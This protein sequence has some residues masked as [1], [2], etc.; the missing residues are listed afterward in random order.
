VLKHLS[1]KNYALIDS[2]EIEFHEGLSII[3]GETGAGKSILLGALSLILGQRADSSVIKNAEGK[4]IVEGIFSIINC[5]LE[6]FFSEN[7]IDLD[8]EAILRREISQDG[9]SRAFINDTPV[10]LNILRDLGVQL[11]DIHSQH[12]NLD[13]NDSRFQLNIID[14]FSGN[15]GLLDDYKTTFKEYIKVKTNLEKLTGEAGKSKEDFEYFKYRFDELEKARLEE[16]EKEVLEEE[17]SALGHSDDIQRN[18]ANIFNYFSENPESVIF[19]LN[20]SLKSAH[21]ISEY[22][23]KLKE[24]SQRIE[25][26]FIEIKDV[27]SEIEIL[28]GK[29]QFDPERFAFVNER[30]DLIYNL[31]QKHK[32]SSIAELDR[33][34]QEL[35]SKINDIESFDDRLKALNEDFL[36]KQKNLETLSEQL[37]KKRKTSFDTIE[38]Y[39]MEQ[40]KSL[41][42]P[43]AAFFVRHEIQADFTPNGKDKI[44]FLFSANKNGE[45]QNI[46]KVAS[47]GEISRLMLSIKSLISKSASLPTIIF[48]EIDAGVSGEIADKMGS[49]MLKMADYMQVVNITHLPQVAAKGNTHYLVYKQDG[50]DKTTTLIRK[51]KQEERLLEIAKMLSGEN[52]SP[53]ALENAKVLLNG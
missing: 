41:G 30:L 8:S 1:V 18:L 23:P 33:I 48:D 17:Q 6:D 51:L 7:E 34:K 22:M 42:M 3:T 47:G 36:Q 32:V 50:A 2:V 45:V 25:S 35:F 40:L 26:S 14:T 28:A 39:V 5:G 38:R 24:L 9:K 31:L 53:Q 21:H 13:L 16:N 12:Q 52:M 37:T 44:N 49:I 10:N 20:E 27:A 19:C 29:I 46:A 11:V 15:S 4:C 43:N